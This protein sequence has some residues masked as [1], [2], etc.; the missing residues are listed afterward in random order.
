MVSYIKGRTWAVAGLEQGA[1]RNISK[2]NEATTY[3][4][5]MHNN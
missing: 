2:E 5:K 1:D 3:W 4:R